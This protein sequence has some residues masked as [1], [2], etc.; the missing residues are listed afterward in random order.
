MQVYL[1][2]NLINGKMYVGQTVR[3]MNVRW[4]QHKQETSHVSCLRNAIKKYGEENFAIDNLHACNS[5]EEMDFV[6]IFYIS[7]LNTKSPNGYNLTEGG[8]GTLGIRP[9]K[10]TREKMRVAKKGKRISPGTEIK[11]GQR[12]SP[13]TEI[14][15]GQRLSPSTEFKK[16]QVSWNKG[17][18][19]NTWTGR[20]HTPESRA[21]MRVSRLA[22]LARKREEENVREK[23]NS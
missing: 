13:A 15:Q 14:K 9:S 12:M 21:K 23:G 17:K 10:E 11:P 16:G 3:P 18:H 6:E 2:T 5:K 19:H 8:E 4:Y 7:F 1:V 20:K 22:M